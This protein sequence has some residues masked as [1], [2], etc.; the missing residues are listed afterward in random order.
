[1][2]TTHQIANELLQLPDVPLE[3]EGWCRVD[4]YEVVAEMTAHSPDSV[5]II[6]QK[7]D[8]SYDWVQEGIDEGWLKWQTCEGQHGYVNIKQDEAYD[9]K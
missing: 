4:K 3:I 1:M 5:A 2:K 8:E 9:T 7:P 6:W